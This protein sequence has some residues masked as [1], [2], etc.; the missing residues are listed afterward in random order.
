MHLSTCCWD[1]TNIRRIDLTLKSTCDYR[2][3]HVFAPDKMEHA[4]PHN[5]QINCLQPEPIKERPEEKPLQSI[6]TPCLCPS[7]GEH[8]AN[9]PEEPSESENLEV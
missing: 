8:K 6:R 4:V 5:N 9:A 2:I 1:R 3:W 7:V